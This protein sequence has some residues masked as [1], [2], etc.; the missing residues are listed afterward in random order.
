MTCAIKDI[1][2]TDQ[3]YV[4]SVNMEY[5]DVWEKSM[6]VSSNMMCVLP[7]TP[8]IFPSRTFYPWQMQTHVNTKIH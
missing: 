4:S 6:A 2:D 8:Q 1:E 5:T 7:I 3:G